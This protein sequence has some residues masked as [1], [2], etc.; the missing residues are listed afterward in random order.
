[1]SYD[2]IMISINVTSHQS[3]VAVTDPHT[4]C[5]ESVGAIWVR[6]MGGFEKAQ[7]HKE[8]RKEKKKILKVEI[9]CQCESKINEADSF[10][11]IPGRLTGC[12]T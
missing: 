7:A 4:P 1:M 10:L 9:S 8:K 11:A 3:N 12:L 5:F 2:K 6:F